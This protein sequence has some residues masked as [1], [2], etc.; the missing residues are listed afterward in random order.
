MHACSCRHACTSTPSPSHQPLFLASSPNS[1]KQ[2]EQQKQQQQQQGPKG[3][4]G[5]DLK[6][7]IKQSKKAE[8]QKDSTKDDKAANHHLF[9]N[10]LKGHTDLV[11]GLSWS[12]DGRFIATACDDQVRERGAAVGPQYA[13]VH[14]S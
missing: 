2:D 14:P 4:K 3:P 12:L 10:T 1:S 8:S 5:P 11:Q 7:L 9:I 13:S 6:T